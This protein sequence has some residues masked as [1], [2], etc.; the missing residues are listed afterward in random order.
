MVPR[1]SRRR[2]IAAVEIAVFGR[3]DLLCVQ[4]VP[5]LDPLLA[6]RSFPNFRSHR[7]SASASHGDDEQAHDGDSDPNQEE[8]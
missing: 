5:S 7:A 8:D 3:G 4:V 2:P 1:M 6:C